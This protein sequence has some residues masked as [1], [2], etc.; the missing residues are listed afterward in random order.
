MK[1]Q[2][3]SN[4][5]IT[6]SFSVCIRQNSHIWLSPALMIIY[7]NCAIER[8]SDWLTQELYFDCWM[9]YRCQ[10]RDRLVLLDLP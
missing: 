8:D 9:N 5:V 1:V 3:V 2:N 4:L 10:V 7:A 6:R